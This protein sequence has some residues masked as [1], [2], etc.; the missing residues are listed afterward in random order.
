MRRKTNS[1]TRWPPSCPP[2]CRTASGWRAVASSH[3]A[4]DA[5]A[6]RLRCLPF[7]PRVLHRPGRQCGPALTY[8]WACPCGRLESPRMA[9]A[10]VLDP[11]LT[12]LRA[13]I[14][15]RGGQRG[16]MMRLGAQDAESTWWR[17][18]ARC[19]R[20]AG[21]AQPAPLAAPRLRG[22][23]PTRERLAQRAAQKHAQ[24]CSLPAHMYIASTTTFIVTTM[25]AGGQQCLQI[26]KAK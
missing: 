15:S 14:T 4:R 24:S 16:V 10:A 2:C 12:E 22:I 6:L 8:G 19:T 18:N 7:T 5:M 13:L 9:A 20:M 17:Q 21:P 1:C 23:A 11:A 26:A 25:P 3:A